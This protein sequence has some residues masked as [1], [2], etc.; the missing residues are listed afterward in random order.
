[1]PP[2]IEKMKP[3]DLCRYSLLAD[4][5]REMGDV[6]RKCISTVWTRNNQ[7]SKISDVFE[8]K[9]DVSY[10]IVGR[11]AC[12]I[13]LLPHSESDTRNEAKSS[14]KC[15]SLPTTEVYPDTRI[16]NVLHALFGGEYN[17]SMLSFIYLHISASQASV[18]VSGTV[19]CHHHNN[20]KQCD[21]V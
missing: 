5:Q 15:G 8:D 4:Q 3:L 21:D 9:I 11:L 18:E 2:C 13:Y 12:R 19:E 14:Y 10:L 17:F 7:R 6:K 1:M 16:A 20:G